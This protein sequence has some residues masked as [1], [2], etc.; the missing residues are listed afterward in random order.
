MRRNGGTKEKHRNTSS[1]VE[2]ELAAASIDPGPTVLT[3]STTDESPESSMRTLRSLL[4]RR[5]VIAIICYAFLAFI[6][7]CMV[8]LQP[9]MYSSSV[10]LGGLGFSSLTI[11]LIE[12]VW[13][14]F[15]GLF[16]V[17][18]FPRLVRIFGARSLFIASFSCYLVCFAA[19][20]IMGVLS[21]KSG[22]VGGAVWAVLIVQL[23][24][25]MLAYMGYGEEICHAMYALTDVE[26]RLHIHLGQRRRPEDCA[27]RTERS[28]PNSRL[29]YACNCPINSFF[30]FLRFVGA[31]HHWGKHGI[32]C[33][34]CDYSPGCCYVYT[35]PKACARQ[36]VKHILLTIF[37]V[38]DYY[39]FWWVHSSSQS[40]YQ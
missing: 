33:V 26:C 20:P 28:S 10:S 27:R 8:V 16:S 9:L 1:D 17:F 13:G 2:R 4:I 23:G 25:Y 5:I 3:V 22:R 24:A 6:D 32:H 38:A 37:W 18:A 21:H 36:L 39:V 14:I 31:E 34:G 15:N 29:A 35:N 19:F 11:G 7:Q 30:P 40:V 12:G